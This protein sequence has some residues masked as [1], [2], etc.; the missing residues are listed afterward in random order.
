MDDIEADFIA[1][2]HIKK[3]KK[4]DGPKFLRL[5]FRLPFYQGATRVWI[6]KTVDEYEKKPHEYGTGNSSQPKKTMSMAEA[7][8]RTNNQKR[9]DLD[10]INSESMETGGGLLFDRVTV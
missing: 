1:I 5:A 2:Y 4:L 8:G 6:Q 9:D 7:V 10:L 3:W